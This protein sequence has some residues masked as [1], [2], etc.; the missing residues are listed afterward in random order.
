MLNEYLPLI[1]KKYESINEIVSFSSFI[2]DDPHKE[3]LIDGPY[4]TG[5]ELTK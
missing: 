4:G 5:L 3:Y 1:I 2:S